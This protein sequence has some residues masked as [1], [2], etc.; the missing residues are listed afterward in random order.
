VENI[1]D[2]ICQSLSESVGFI[3]DTTKTRGLI[4]LVSVNVSMWWQ[5]VGA[6]RQIA[7]KTGRS[8]LA[9]I[10]VTNYRVSCGMPEHVRQRRSFAVTAY[11]SPILWTTIC[12][13]AH[14]TAARYL[15]PVT[16]R[17]NDDAV[18]L[19]SPNAAKRSLRAKLSRLSKLLMTLTRNP[20]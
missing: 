15:S 2:I 14:F 13:S 4:C 3:E 7:D 6:T 12:S 20:C 5:V 11:L 16:H 10:S 9:S 17:L 1:Q 8:R 19:D 18:L